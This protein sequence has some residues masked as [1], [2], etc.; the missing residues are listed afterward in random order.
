MQKFKVNYLPLL[1]IIFITS[2]FLQTNAQNKLKKSE[3]LSVT[4]H[5]ITVNG[6]TINYEATTGYMTMKEEDG[7]ENANVFFIAYTKKGVENAAE[8]PVTFAYNGGPGSSSVWLHMG[9]LGPKRILMTDEGESLPPPYK[10]ADNEYT[11]LDETDLVFIDPVMTGYSRPADSVKKEEFHG[12]REDLASVGDFIRLYLSRYERWSS[13]K[14]LAGESYGT[15]RSAG[16]SGYLQD[17]HGI[18]LNGIVLISS[19]LNW[20]TVSFDFGNELPY[21][22]HLPTY[23]AIAWYHKKAGTSYSS[24]QEFLK[25]VE[26]FALNDYTVALMKGD[27]LPANEK[28]EIVSK[29]NKYTGLSEEYIKQT[30]LRIEIGRF[31]KELLRSDMKTVGR[32]DGRFTGTDLDAA[33]ERFEYDPSYNKTIYGPYTRAINDYVRAE[34]DYENDLPYEI[35]TGRVRPWNWGVE[36]EYVDVANTLRASMNKNPHLKI[37]VCNGF[38]DLATPYFATA[39]TFNHLFLNE[40]LQKNISMTYYEAGH[41]M[42]IHMPSLQQLKKDVANFYQSSK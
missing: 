10:L 34:L 32:L 11:W 2:G 18:Y 41:M 39:Y 33:G 40:E 3:S 5:Q 42:Y 35:L 6:K 4:S 38:Y 31:T 37:L 20:Q 24:V 1:L 36:N 15:T 19:I 27:K 25:E 17:R 14:F 26:E 7:K 22:L 21:V 28:Q 16:L 30:L 13:P 9:A 8:R 23:A 12:L 29:L